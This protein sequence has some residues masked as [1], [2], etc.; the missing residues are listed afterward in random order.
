M[1]PL[2]VF[3]SHLRKVIVQQLSNRMFALSWAKDP[4]YSPL[5]LW[6]GETG[7]GC[8]SQLLGRL[9]KSPG[10]PRRRKESGALEKEKRVWDSQGGEKDKH[11]IFPILLCLSQYNN[12]PCSRMFLLNKNLLTNLVILKLV[13]C[14][15]VSGKIFLLLLLI[16]LS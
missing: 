14:G 13:Y 8:E 4:H 9:I 10:T 15:S 11:F 6:S 7:F 12:V 16:L 5:R 2:S 1:R 3:S